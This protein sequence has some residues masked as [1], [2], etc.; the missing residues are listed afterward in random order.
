M[1]TRPMPEGFSPESMPDPAK[2][3]FDSDNMT[4][5]GVCGFL[6]L[7]SEA[8]GFRRYPIQGYEVYDDV[9]YMLV[10]FRNPS[11]RP[12]IQIHKAEPRP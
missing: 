10:S 8:Y 7:G 4:V 6:S 5:L 11:D 2:G 9:K 3:P 12:P 1:V